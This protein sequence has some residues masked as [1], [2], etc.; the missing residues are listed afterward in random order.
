MQ[1]W[2]HPLT[3]AA[4]VLVFSVALAVSTACSTSSPTWTECCEPG[5]D[6]TKTCVPDSKD[7]D[8]LPNT[9]ARYGTRSM[10]EYLARRGA[11]R[12]AADEKFVRCVLCQFKGDRGCAFLGTLRLG[13][14]YLEKGDPTT[15]MKRFNQAWLINPNSALVYWGFGA[16]YCDM[17]QIDNGL[18][19]FDEAVQLNAKDGQLSADQL[20]ALY[21]DFGFALMQKADQ[22]QQ[23]R[24]CEKAKAYLERASGL[25][26]KSKETHQDSGCCTY[27]KWA[28]VLFVMGNY[29]ESW[30]KVHL[31]QTEEKQCEIPAPFLRELRNAMPEP[32]H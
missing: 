7:S 14:D 2:P 16:T 18:E 21:C 24:V 32:I 4:S 5:G 31:S 28:V 19:M 20:S 25:F 29:E 26:Q 10:E 1:Y 27:W 30:K 15:A 23:E 9:V 12:K 11:C 3:T 17:R 13:W 8:Y 22:C 6:V